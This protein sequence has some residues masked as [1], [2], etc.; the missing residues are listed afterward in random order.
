MSVLHA[1][2]F[3]VPAT[4]APAKV[5]TVSEVVR[6]ANLLLQR[7]YGQ[8]WVEG[9]ISG[10]KVFPS[11]H[12]YLTLKDAGASMSCIVYRTRL[13][14]LRFEPTDGMQVICAGA[15]GIYE[16]RG[17]FQLNID[18]MEP[19][20][21]GALQQAFEQL[22]TKLA[23]EGLFDEA[24][25]RP[26]PLFPERIGIV[27][28]PTGA[29]IHDMLQILKRRFAGLHIVINPVRVQGEGAAAEIARAI[30]ELN[31]LHEH[32][33][34]D[35]LIVG[36]GGGSLE[37]L[38]AFNEEIVARAI[39]GSMIPI[40]S[41]VGHE[42]DYTIADF[43]ADKR[44][45]TPSEAAEIVI[46][47]KQEFA[48][49]IAAAR[50][51]LDLH[52]THR[53]DDAAQRL[54]TAMTSHAFR[55]PLLLV[56]QAQQRMTEL[57]RRAQQAIMHQYV[58]A[59]HTL[60]GLAGKLQ[61]LNPQQQLAAAVVRLTHATAALHGAAQRA[62][63]AL[64]TQAKSL[65]AQLEALSPLAILARGYSATFHADGERL[66]THARDVRVGEQLRTQLAAGEV[67]SRV[68]STKETAP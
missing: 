50:D 48:E 66:V 12:A 62:V 58:L 56:Q 11:G 24:R 53:L 6:A 54:R 39:A 57:E 5:Y 25:K 16:A 22:K 64:S 67:I 35:V 13:S 17:T 10:F 60:A 61:A 30:Q 55:Q 33:A 68:E 21:L 45:K 44:A 23:A 1:A 28:S 18:R 29:A 19:K 37:D 41:A 40:I 8:V 20:G 63:T 32:L 65:L 43:V 51:H 38:W 7:S 4:D 52:V 3:G 14:K 47:T 59:R 15:L 42:V 26:L 36:R 34:I 9:E 49:R 46:A 27:T 31:L 2:R